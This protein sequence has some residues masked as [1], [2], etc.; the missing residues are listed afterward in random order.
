MA[1]YLGKVSDHRTFQYS[2]LSKDN[3]DALKARQIAHYRAMIEAIEQDTRDFDRYLRYER[4]LRKMI[5]SGRYKYERLKGLM[6]KVRTMRWYIE[7]EFGHSDDHC[8]SILPSPEGY[9]QKLWENARDSAIARQRQAERSAQ[10]RKMHDAINR[11]EA[12]YDDFC[13]DCCHKWEDTDVDEWIDYEE[14][15][16]HQTWYCPECTKTLWRDKEMW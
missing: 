12:S 16:I 9:A 14:E 4:K 3:L 7:E 6:S 13:P 15:V 11:G 5:I 1:I 2:F 10:Y 8:V